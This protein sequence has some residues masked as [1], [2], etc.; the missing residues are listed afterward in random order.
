M[1]IQG[2]IV[3]GLNA[4]FHDSAAAIIVGGVVIAAAAE[5]RFTRIKHDSG[6]PLRAVEFCLAEAG[7]TMEE[8]DHVVFYEKPLRKFE[9]VMVTQLRAFPRGL[10]Q[11]I[12]ATSRW[13]GK[14]LWLEG[15]LCKAL[16][17]H[18]DQLL[19]SDH[20]LSHA[21]SAW[22]RSP[23]AGF[24]T[25]ADPAS[26][27]PTAVITA[28]GVGEW[29]T[30]TVYGAGDGPDGAGLTLLA[31]QRFPHSIGLLYSALT[32][33]LGFRVNNGEYKV[34]GLAAYGTPRFEAAFDKFVTV[35]DVDGAVTLNLDFL[36]H[37]RS[38]TAAFTPALEKLLGAARVPDATLSLPA[39]TSEDQRFADLAATLQKVC[40]RAM[41]GVARHAKTL[42]G[43][44]RL[45]MAG[46]VALNSV[47]NTR[48]AHEAGFDSVYVH[49]AAGDAGGALGAALWA[50]H[51][52]LGVPLHAASAKTKRTEHA[53]E[54]GAPA[55][56][57]GLG[58]G[59]TNAEVEQTLKDVRARYQTFETDEAL[60]EAVAQRLEE[61]AVGAWFR[62]R[63]EWGP[64]SLGQRSILAD[65][66]RADMTDRINRKIKF[67]E[68][69]RPFAPAILEGDAGTYFEVGP[70]TQQLT[71]HM[72][73]VV[74]VKP[75]G[76]ETFPAITH[77][78]G[79][80]RVQTVSRD[81]APDFAAL[82]EAFKARTGVGCLL[83]T[84]LN[85]KGEPLCASP[86]DAY[87]TFK[88][89]GLDFVVM[90][91]CLVSKSA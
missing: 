6:L 8:V 52:V 89:S 29:A 45:C 3:L 49:P 23:F 77:V 38:A 13:L 18:P 87:A 43:A 9:R 25:D 1:D 70:A 83:N 40:E 71:P 32:A 72:L 66:R 5:E 30:T 17:V 19:Y 51:A 68:A 53:G 12:S 64:R 16:D 39:V 36:C 90:E 22:Y 74:D 34:M 82:L 42:T 50:T 27:F 79:T 84:S 24:Q 28:D 86:L 85:L 44:S 21:A 55:A 2:P 10:G 57:S 81:T 48:I 7:V 62:G 69:F 33:Y 88:R 91:R 63:F 78:D 46:G 35:D 65:P 60:Y 56:A 20:H 73:A 37:D 11:F 80:A 4:H 14:R 41:L 54:L 26:T 67:R 31:E 61:G 58:K 47:A 59:Y 75:A 15:E 76:R